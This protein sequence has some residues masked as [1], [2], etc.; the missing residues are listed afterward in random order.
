MDYKIV[1]LQKHGDKNGSLVALESKK[2]IPFE[3]KRV[4]YI[5]GTKKDFVRGKHS[6]RNLKQYIVCVSGS[7]DFVLDDGKKKKLLRLDSPLS[8]IYVEGNVWREFTNFSKDCVIL[9]L[10]NQHYNEKDYIRDYE[11]FLECKK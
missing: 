11:K 2:N 6:H 8:A 1:K 5:F 7:C 10:A 4:Y 9:V 3:I